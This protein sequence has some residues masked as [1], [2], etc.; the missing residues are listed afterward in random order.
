MSVLESTSHSTTSGLDFLQDQ[1]PWIATRMRL[2]ALT[3]SQ[4]TDVSFIG[5]H[6][7]LVSFPSI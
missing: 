6:G 5:L 7:Y 4:L 2:V 1:A 3:S